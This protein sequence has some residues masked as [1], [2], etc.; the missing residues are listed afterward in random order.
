MAEADMHRLAANEIPHVAAKASPSADDVLHGRILR[1]E[2]NISTVARAEDSERAQPQQGYAHP[3]WGPR[4]QAEQE[5]SCAQ[6]ITHS[7]R[8]ARCERRTTRNGRD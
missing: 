7:G 2:L 1:R 4:A 3:T 8:G 5:G 6:S